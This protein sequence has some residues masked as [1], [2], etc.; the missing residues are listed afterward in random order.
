MGKCLVGPEC[1]DRHSE[2]DHHD[3]RNLSHGSLLFGIGTGSETPPIRYMVKTHAHATKI[4]RFV[5]GPANA[6]QN[7]LTAEES[8][9]KPKSLAWHLPVPSCSTRWSGFRGGIPF[10]SLAGRFSV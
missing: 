4:P 2:H 6:K 8:P 3:K 1:E 9:V 5:A 10:G 7:S